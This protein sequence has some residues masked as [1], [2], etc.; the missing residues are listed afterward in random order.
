MNQQTGLNYF[1]FDDS[2]VVALEWIT[3]EVQQ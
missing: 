1:N 3:I 2:N